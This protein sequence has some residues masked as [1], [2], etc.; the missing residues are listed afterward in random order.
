MQNVDWRVHDGDLKA[1]VKGAS[2]QWEE[3]GWCPQ[4][5]SQIVFLA[6][7]VYETL[8][9]GTRGP[10]KSDALIVDYAQHCIHGWGNKWK[11]LILRRTFPELR[12][13]IEKADDILRKTVPGIQWNANEHEFT[14]PTG[15]ILRFGQFNRLPDYYKYHGQQYQFLGWDELTNWPD[16]YGYRKMMSL[17][18]SPVAAIPEMIRATTNPFGIGHG[19]VKE[20]FR[21]PIPDG[22]IKGKVIR[23]AV[24]PEGKE[25]RE[26]LSVRGKLRENKILLHATPEYEKTLQTAATSDAELKAWMLGDWDIVAGGMF[27]DVW[28]SLTHFIEPFTVPR[29]WRLDRSFDWGSSS[30]FSV[31]WWAESDG[32]D[33]ALKD[34]AV[35]STVRGDLF[36]IGEWY[37]WN[38]RPNKGLKLLNSDISKGIIERELAWGI[39][40]RVKA[41]PADTSIFTVENGYS[42]ADDMA[43]QVR[44]HGRLM[45]GPR[46]TRADKASGSRKSGWEKMRG[47]FQDA[48]GDPRMPRERPG[49]FIF[50]TCEQFRRTVPVLPRDEIKMDDV[51]TDSEDHIADEVRYRVKSTGTQVKQTQHVGMY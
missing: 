41:G 34:G 4:N 46:W 22:Y 51:D 8:Y 40:D 35:M 33:V 17:C 11:G 13:L 38:G 29:E 10:G 49:L 37:G 23:D 48:I 7:N 31:G 21:L 25:E 14:W 19:W 1:F 16:D 28:D 26:R 45:P 27:N 43:K 30:P 39:H 15:E 3:A 42:Y 24:S 18:R 5:G 12:E 20:R 47:M 6:S 32:S 9:E 44:V 50:N 36:R 2:G